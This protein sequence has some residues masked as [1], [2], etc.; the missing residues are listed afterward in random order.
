MVDGVVA[1]QQ[2][3]R[4]GEQDHHQPHRHPARGAVHLGRRDG[5]RGC[6]RRAAA[7]VRRRYDQR[8]QRLPVLPDQNLDRFADALAEHLGE[9][10]LPLAR[11]AHRLQQ[12]RRGAL[13]RR[14]PQRGVEQRAQRHE[15]RGQ[16]ALVEPQLQV[17]L[18]P[19]VVV[20]PGEQQ[21][22]LAA[23]GHQ[24]QVIAAGAQPAERLTDAAAAA[25]DA[26]APLAVQEHRQRRAAAALPQVVRL[27]D[28][29]GNGAPPPGGRHAA[30]A[31]PRAGGGV[32]A[33]D[34]F[35]Y[36][37]GEA[38]P[39]AAAA[40]AVRGR[41]AQECGGALAELAGGPGVERRR[42]EGRQLRQPRPVEQQAAVAQPLP[43]GQA[44]RFPCFPGRPHP[45][46]SGRRISAATG[47]T[48]AEPAMAKRLGRRCSRRRARSCCNC[49]RSS[50]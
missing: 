17:P 18:A 46:R 5:R 40:A 42:R 32:Q 19:G 8:A 48:R 11:V 43:A 12:R 9:I 33:A 26:D 47:N 20:Q 14:R 23:V 45:R 13:G 4:L 29:A 1:R 38:G 7:G 25:A 35:Q 27:D 49:A 22:P 41:A 2:I 39:V 37:R 31:R 21:P 15:L 44:G 10:R 3:A 30:A 36:E 16:F 50:S 34:S 24:R 28:L 6:R